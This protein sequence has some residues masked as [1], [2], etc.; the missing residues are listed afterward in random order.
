MRRG[1]N[2]C[3]AALDRQ[4]Q[5]SG[6][7]QRMG[8]LSEHHPAPHGN[9]SRQHWRSR[10]ARPLQTTRAR[11]PALDAIS[12]ALITSCSV[13]DLPPAQDIIAIQ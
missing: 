1:R 9:R 6:S 4:C 12:A 3:A 8:V 7:A 10:K 5:I 11:G 13:I 2:A